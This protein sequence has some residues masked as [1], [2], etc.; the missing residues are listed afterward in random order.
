M[1]DEQACGEGRGKP[2]E[3]LGEGEEDSML[4]CSLI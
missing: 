2:Y 4:A 1:M 3:K